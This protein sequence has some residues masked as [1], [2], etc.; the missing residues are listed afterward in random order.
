M[1]IDSLLPEKLGQLSNLNICFES[2][3]DWYLIQLIVCLNPDFKCCNNFP[4]SS[5]EVLSGKWSFVSVI[6]NVVAWFEA[7]LDITQF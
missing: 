4:L 5:V 3:F 7:T 2:V 1:S 6:A